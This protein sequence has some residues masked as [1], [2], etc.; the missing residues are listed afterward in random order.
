MGNVSPFPSTL[1]SLL[2]A[3]MVFC[4]LGIH[5]PETLA[6][7]SAE[8]RPK[9]G[10]V[11][12]G[13]GARG[14]AHIGVLK[15]LEKQHIKIDYI[16][17]TSM[18]AL[19][20]G[21]YAAGLS[22]KQIENFATSIDW[23]STFN[24]EPIRYY[25][26]FRRKRQQ[27]E[28]FIKGEVGM[29]N[30]NLLLPSGALQGQKQ[31]L[32]LES[33]LL[34]TT[35]SRNFDRLRIPFRAVAT[36]ITTGQ[37]YIL[38]QGNLAHALRASMS[39]PGIFAPVEIDGHLL[40]D[41]GI[42]NN[43]PVSVVRNMG[44]DIVIVSDIHDERSKKDKLKN[45]LDIANQLITGLTLNNTLAQLATLKPKDIVIRPN[46]NDIGSADFAKAATIIDAG[47]TATEQPAMQQALRP[48]AVQQAFPPKLPKP[49]SL[50][51]NQ[52][53]IDNQ[54]A[55]AEA[56]IRSHLHQKVGQPL[57][58]TQLE[59]DLTFLYGLGFFKNIS[60]DFFQEN[61]QGILRIHTTEPDWGP[62]F[63]KLKFNLASNL[64][65]QT[66][67]NLGLRHIY[68]PANDLGA[69]WRNE[70]QIGE[71]KKL[72]TE[73]YQ[74]LDVQQRYY[75]KPFA[76]YDD[77]NYTL[78]SDQFGPL[79]LDFEKQRIRTGMDFGI[80]LS[81]NSRLSTGLFYEDG[82]LV[83]GSKTRNET[84]D[85]YHHTTGTVAFEHDSLDQVSFP[86][87]GNL[88]EVRLSA[89]TA[90]LYHPDPIRSDQAKLS[91]YFS[92][93]RHT[94][95]LYAE[96]A[97]I[98]TNTPS[99]NTEFYT[100]G[101]F[102]HLSGFRENELLGNKI[103]FARLKYQY[104][105][106]GSSSNLINFPVYVGTTLEAGN[107]YGDFEHQGSIDWN[108]TKQAGSLFIGMNSFVGPLYLAYG[109]HNAQI[110][111]LYFYFG[112]DFD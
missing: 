20:G 12:A 25:Q 22:V 105:L 32:L 57:D 85:K 64:A 34:N 50:L 40:V 46:L 58:R 47:E 27:F 96:Y 88:F 36:D 10:L 33:L 29:K 100:L 56:V 86:S 52:I 112:R 79:S 89:L 80:N 94:V 72:G 104:R 110:Q 42:T 13:G 76:T 109:Y 28:Y 43:T 23:D 101:G 81:T 51:V 107:V 9:V 4:C 54:T 62:N 93:Q 92:W 15:A 55:I 77:R 102:Q 67:F 84:I 87:K 70:I 38:K 103:A 30:G 73:F 78:T 45:F 82:Q 44:A 31:D 59:S 99:A 49:P 108:N 24:D 83:V 14:L 26:S 60:Y 98:L 7:P 5:A 69:E 8:H 95:N 3:G 37:P 11:L 65:D 53:Q 6:A 91:Q 90:D 19:V 74:P 17:G 35:H 111:S 48:Y 61:H 16:A 2:L 97:N 41:G 63:F 18:G 66:L 21:L 75:W 106:F 68:M 1:R 71:E 39:V